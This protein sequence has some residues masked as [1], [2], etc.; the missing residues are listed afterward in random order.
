MNKKIIFAPKYSTATEGLI[1]YQYKPLSLFILFA[2]PCCEGHEF[3]KLITY[4][5][6]RW[7]AQSLK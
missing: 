1:L 3:P 2:T 5:C 4:L 6:E 7:F